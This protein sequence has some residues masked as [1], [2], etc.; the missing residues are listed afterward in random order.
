M[1]G[2][3]EPSKPESVLG[4]QQGVVLELDEKNREIPGL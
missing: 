4:I 3:I 2:T 1:M